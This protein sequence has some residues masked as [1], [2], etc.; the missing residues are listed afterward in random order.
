[1]V[2]E[3]KKQRFSHL[4]KHIRGNDGVKEFAARINVKLPTYSCWETGRAFPSD[5][6]W[7]TL[8]PQL[9]E[10][11]GFMPESIDRYL[12]GDYEL[13]DL[14]EGSGLAELQPRSRSL[15]T[16]ARF[17]EWLHRL[18]LSESIQ[19]LKDAAEWVVKLASGEDNLSS[20]TPLAT[21][22]N[23]LNNSDSNS[24]RVGVDPRDHE[25]VMKTILNLTE[26]LSLEEIVQVD[27]HLRNLLDAKLQA[28]GLLERRKYQ[29]HPLYLLM[30]DYRANNN[31]TYAQF[32]EQLLKEGKEAGLEP[33]RLAKIV[34]GQVLP[35]NRE[36]IWIGVFM[37]KPDGNLYDHEEL[38]W[39][40]DG[41][42]L[43]D[44]EDSDSGP[45]DEFSKTARSPDGQPHDYPDHPCECH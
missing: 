33:T 16:H 22:E 17:K 28:L 43:S 41:R 7:E 2:S 30:E 1:M 39:L 27:N 44:S 24:L 20:K 5:R 12:R 45:D 40:R 21:P 31:L 13:E 19:I 23:P 15:M 35:N 4:L 26:H 32:E 14:I 38:V 10:L 3:E 6:L 34:R 42:G 9:C 25:A 8:L 37:R 11:S 18:S 29:T 36:L